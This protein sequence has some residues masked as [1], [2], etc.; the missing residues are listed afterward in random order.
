MGCEVR[1]NCIKALESI[2][3]ELDDLVQIPAGDSKINKLTKLV[4]DLTYCVKSQLWE[5]E[6]ASED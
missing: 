5:E 6:Y 2:E 1:L 4:S 3:S